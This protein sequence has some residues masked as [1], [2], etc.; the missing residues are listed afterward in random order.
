MTEP[1]DKAEAKWVEKHTEHEYRKTATIKAV[2]FDGSMCM[3]EKFNITPPMPFDPAYTMPTK[4]GEMEL[5]ISDWIATGV[6]GEHW[7][8]RNTVFKETYERVINQEACKYCHEGFTP[9]DHGPTATGLLVGK[10][11][12]LILQTEISDVHYC[13]MCGRKLGD[14]D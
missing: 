9:L 3:I 14:T 7:A 12:L 1:Q 4:E 8:I 5:G 10:N 2:Q 11:G 13:P 6:E